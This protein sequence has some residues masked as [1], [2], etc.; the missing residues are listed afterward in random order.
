MVK[1][2]QKT[3]VDIN[4]YGPLTPLF[5]TLKDTWQRT[6]KCSPNFYF[7]ELNE[8]NNRHS[9]VKLRQIKI[10]RIFLSLVH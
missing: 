5:I 10:E 7:L 4:N 3:S 9:F 8:L 2:K 1:N 6:Q